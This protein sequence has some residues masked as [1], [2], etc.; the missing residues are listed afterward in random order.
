MLQA[1]NIF[2]SIEMK[3]RNQED[4]NEYI[5]LIYKTRAPIHP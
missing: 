2:D 4:E 5:A 3:T 1:T